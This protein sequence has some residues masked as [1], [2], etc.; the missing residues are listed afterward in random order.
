M[1]APVSLL[2]GARAFARDFPR[3][4]MPKGY[5]WDVVDYVPVIVDAPLTGRGGWRWNSGVLGGDIEGGIY[6]DFTTGNKLFAQATDGHLYE[7][8][9]AD[10]YAATD[11]GAI[12]RSNQN[13]IQYGDTV[14]VLD[15][16]GLQVPTM[17]TAPGGTTTLGKLDASAPKARYGAVWKDYFV[18]GGGTGQPSGAPPEERTVRFS[19]APVTAAWDAQSFHGT[20]LKITGIAALRSAILVFHSGSTQRIRGSIP[21]H[22]LIAGQTDDADTFVEVLSNG[23]GCDDARTIAYWNDNCIFAD[24]HGVHMT[25]GA[26]VRN[27]ASQGGISYYWRV[28]WGNKLSAAGSIFLDYYMITVR[29]TDG[30]DDTLVCD[31]NRRQWFRFSNIPAISY[32]SSSGAPGMERLWAGI[33]NTNRL[34]RVSSCFS[35]VFTLTP[36]SD[37]NGVAVLPRFDTP[38]YRMGAEGRKRMRFVYLSYDSRL[39]GSASGDGAIRIEFADSPEQTLYTALGHFPGTD[40]YRRYRLPLGRFPYGIGFRVAQDQPAAAVRVYDIAVDAQA[41]ERSRV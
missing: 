33:A 20:T 21:P 30:L 41:A 12:V 39:G 14:I 28:L 29:R 31:L 8:T 4:A 25:D 11:R 16:D 9:D 13:P 34:A 1:A 15:R 24:Q 40:R 7:I 18:L 26:V 10:P 37:D 5:L 23:V 22:T 38:W 6:A 35:P 3:D 2:Q 17:I 36:I 27:L 19:P 32:I